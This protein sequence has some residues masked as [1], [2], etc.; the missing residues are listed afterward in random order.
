M[1]FDSEVILGSIL[2][3]TK[4][5]NYPKPGR[6]SFGDKGFYAFCLREKRVIQNMNK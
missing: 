6:I 2:P 3:L 1:A 5:V 4:P